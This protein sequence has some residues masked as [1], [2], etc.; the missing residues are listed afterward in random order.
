MRFLPSASHCV[1]SE[2]TGKGRGLTLVLTL[3]WHKKALQ[4][5]PR[6]GVLAPSPV[7]GSEGAGRGLRMCIPSPQAL[8]M[9]Q[10]E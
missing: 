9:P 2:E 7:S 4:D 5:L 3:E 8:P 6:S 1:Q 10:L